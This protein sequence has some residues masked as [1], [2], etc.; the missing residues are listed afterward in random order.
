MVFS[1]IPVYLDP[2]NWHHH[3]QSN[4]PLVQHDQGGGG[5]G[6]ASASYEAPPPLPQQH[7][8]HQHQLPP[9]PAQQLMPHGGGAGAGVGASIR[10]G[11]MADRARLAKVPQPEPGLKCPRCE[12]TN[13]KFCYFNN[14]NLTQPRHFC[15]TCRRYWTKGGALRNVP[16]GGGCRRNKK[17]SSSSKG[18]KTSGGGGGGSSGSGTSTSSA[19]TAGGGGGGGGG[20]G[21]I[22]P[23]EI[24]GHL[25]HHHQLPPFLAH[26]FGAG[27][28]HHLGMNYGG[29]GSGGG[30]EMGLFQMGGGSS[31]NN[32]GMVHQFPFFETA[33][34]AGN[35]YGGSFQ[36]EGMMSG[37]T[38]TGTSNSASRVNAQLAAHQVKPELQGVNLVT[39]PPFADSDSSNQY[40]GGRGGGNAGASWTDLTGLNSHN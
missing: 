12:S 11:S 32:S 18:N 3:H 13:T 21:M 28:S 30:G 27:S 2:P 33:A 20:V 4:N 35:L 19:A 22:L 15:K 5:G 40:W 6:G 39:R 1:S 9:L 26:Q 38:G 34:A 31:S 36:N 16:V 8:H 24:M 14:Y 23:S 29:G 7:Q 17:S 25:P 37:G 10:P